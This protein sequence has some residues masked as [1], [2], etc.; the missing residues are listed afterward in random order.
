MAKLFFYVHTHLLLDWRKLRALE[1]CIY[2]RKPDTPFE[3]IVYH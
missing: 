3:K 1:A 2:A